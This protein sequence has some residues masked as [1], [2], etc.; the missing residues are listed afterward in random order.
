LTR[1]LQS[2]TLSGD[3]SAAPI[4]SARLGRASHRSHLARSIRGRSERIHFNGP[5]NDSY[6]AWNGTAL[7]NP[8]CKSG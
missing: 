3:G 1:D 6:D 7:K 4:S 5:T 8:K 2:A